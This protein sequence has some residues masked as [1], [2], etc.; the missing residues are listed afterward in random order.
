MLPVANTIMIAGMML[1]R[2]RKGLLRLATKN[3]IGTTINPQMTR[4]T[5]TVIK[6]NPSFLNVPSTS[7]R[8][9]IVLAMRL[10]TPTGVAL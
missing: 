6:Y 10:A 3:I 4:P 5:M 1:A 8:P 9:I 2:N 7:V